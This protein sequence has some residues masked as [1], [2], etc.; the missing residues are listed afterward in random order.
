MKHYL[1]IAALVCIIP[2]R[3]FAQTLPE[4]DP[5]PRAGDCSLTIKI[6][7][8]S[9]PDAVA[10]TLDSPAAP[11]KFIIV[12]RVPLVA[13]LKDPLVANSEVTV[14]VGASS[15][16]ARVAP[17]PEGTAP[18]PV[19]PGTVPKKTALDEREV[20]EASG[21]LGE[22]FDN[23][24]PN[25]SGGYVNPATASDSHSRVTAG[26]DAQYRLVGKPDSEVQ[27]WLT[28]HTLHGMRTADASCADTKTNADCLQQAAAHPGTTF[29]YI[30]GHASTIEAHVDARL[31]LKTI[32]ASETV[33][34]KFY[35]Y[36]R[37][38]F[39]DLEGAPRVYDA[40]SIGAGIIAPKG[41]FRNSYAQI[42]W[43]AS[44]QFATDLKYDR[45]KVN[46]VLV[47]DVVA[48]GVLDT[49]TSIAGRLG[50]GSRFFLAI[51]IDRNLH[52]GPDAVQ[53]YVGFNFDLRKIFGSF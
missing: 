8:G 26:V 31:E 36:V 30:L 34:A 38:G 3:A 40:N 6:P 24:A 15:A 20:F 21:Y 27:L 28:A 50:K 7:A 46:G 17:A 32:Q 18:G 9:N 48:P 19:C 47:F 39:L 14:K 13:A 43:G 49:S 42:G 25:V 52:D 1:V 29:Y 23:F 51:S 22:V 33:P 11:L 16:V 35:L 2:Y 4:I 41:V 5:K 44:K 10:I 37:A 53:T 45:M 12:Q